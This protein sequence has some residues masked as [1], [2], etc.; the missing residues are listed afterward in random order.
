MSYPSWSTPNIISL[1]VAWKIGEIFWVAKNKRWKLLH[2][3]IR[4]FLNIQVLKS[5]K[6]LYWNFYNF[7]SKFQTFY[8][9]LIFCWIPVLS[10]DDKRK[11]P[12]FSWKFC[13][14]NRVQ[15]LL[16]YYRQDK[17][18]LFLIS[19]VYQIL[20][21]TVYIKLKKLHQF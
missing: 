8:N 9:N 21:H 17:R 11:N 1:Y 14:A 13:R 20:V 15:R 7:P 10:N 4:K 5:D 12:V 16:I 19:C 2:Y 3:T 18:F 6:K